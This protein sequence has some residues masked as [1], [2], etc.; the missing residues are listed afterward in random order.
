MSVIRFWG[1]NC[2]KMFIFLGCG[3]TTVKNDHFTLLGCIITTLKKSVDIITLWRHN[4]AQMFMLLGY[5]IATAL[6][7]FYYKAMTSQ[8]YSNVYFLVVTSQLYKISS[9]LHNFHLG[10]LFEISPE[11]LRLF[12]LNSMWPATLWFLRKVFIRKSEEILLSAKPF[13]LT[14][15]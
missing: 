8:L 2:S 14:C 13:L 9:S 7:C 11:F 15:R 5:D 1:H 10:R 4:C 3:N 6:K 12:E